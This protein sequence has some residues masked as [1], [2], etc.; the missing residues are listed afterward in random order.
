VT[1]DKVMSE[2]HDTPADNK[3]GTNL[4]HGT[5][6]V[7]RLQRREIDYDVQALQNNR[8]KCPLRD[9]AIKSCCKTL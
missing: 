7:A 2:I 5:G 4:L 9:S 3:S 6:D 1:S 8:N